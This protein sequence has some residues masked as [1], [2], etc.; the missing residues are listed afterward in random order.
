MESEVARHCI[1]ESHGG[2]LFRSGG[3]TACRYTDGRI[4]VTN[5]HGSFAL[6]DV[7]AL[8]AELCFTA[9]AVLDPR[10]LFDVLLKPVLILLFKVCGAYFVHAASVLGGGRSIMFVGEQGVGKSTIC[11]MSIQAGHATLADDQHL[12]RMTRNGQVEALGLPSR[13]NLDPSIAAYVPR[14]GFLSHTAARDDGPKRSFVID[15]VYPRA[16]RH[17]CVPTHL[18]LLSPPSA[19][20]SSFVR[21]LAKADALCRLIRHS[22]TVFLDLGAPGAHLHALTQLVEQCE[23]VQ[24]SLGHDVYHEPSR[25]LDLCAQQMA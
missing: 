11:T 18:V 9:A 20:A 13:F 4:L 21:P 7:G 15:S 22:E 16:L 1:P 17:R 24:A 6:V 10:V 5:R 2:R 8:H 25:V 14:L 19:C 3:I 12:L 23:C